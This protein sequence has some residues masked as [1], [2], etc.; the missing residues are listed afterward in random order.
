MDTY[1]ASQA[2]RRL[3]T[4][5]PRVLRAVR[6]LGMD[7]PK[8][9]SGAL[10][11]SEAD[12]QTLSEELGSG[13]VPTGLTRTQSRVLAALSR[14]PRGLASQ[15]AVARR[16]GVS[17]TAA[18]PAL[19]DLLGAGLVRRE[20]AMVA[21]GRVEEADIYKAAFGDPAWHALAP[22]LARVA[23]PRPDRHVPAKIVPTHLRHLFWNTAPS[24]LSVET[25]A[26]YIAKRLLS[27][28]D[29]DGLAWGATHLPGAAWE[30]AAQA[31]GLTP[32]TRAMAL[33]LAKEPRVAA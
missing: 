19:T 11:L 9:P 28:G 31:R 13:F 32:E 2:A 30:R 29:P 18:G 20:R 27:I 1:S 33:H 5:A 17:P 4:T 26:P 24:Q 8:T 23:L 3:G 21:R 10:A 7:V 14:S 22:E 12:L 15:R 25:S 16:A 6:R